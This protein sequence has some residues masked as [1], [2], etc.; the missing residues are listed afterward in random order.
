MCSPGF[1]GYPQNSLIRKIA[2]GRFAERSHD[3][4]SVML[5]KPIQ[6]LVFV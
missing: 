2:G 1:L 3:R 5:D 4:A 6:D